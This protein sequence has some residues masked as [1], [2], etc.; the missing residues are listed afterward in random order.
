M[1]KCFWF[2]QDKEQRMSLPHTVFTKT[3]ESQKI[4]R[5]MRNKTVITVNSLLEAQRICF[6]NIKKNH[7]TLIWKIS[8][9][10]FLPFPFLTVFALFTTVAQCL[11]QN[12]KRRMDKR[13]EKRRGCGSSGEEQLFLWA[14]HICYKW[15]YV[16]PT[17]SLA[18]VSRT[19]LLP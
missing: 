8:F 14:L 3:S 13:R 19:R 16:P 9:L 11:W 15:Q 7:Y 17:F 1:I 5:F 18:G 10:F 12:E 6:I 2:F 4:F